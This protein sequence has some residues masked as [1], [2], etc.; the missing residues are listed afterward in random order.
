MA[1]KILLLSGNHICHNPR[2]VK[3]ADAISQLGNNV[4]VLGMSFLPHLVK[5]DLELVLSKRWKYTAVPG[6]L[7]RRVNVKD[8]WYRLI[9]WVA[10][11]VASKTGIQTYAQLGGWKKDLLKQARMRNVDLTI[12]HSPATLWVVRELMRIGRKVAV[13]FEDWFSREHV[14]G[15]WYPDKLIT[16]LERDVIGRAIHATCTSEAMAL[17]I[18]KAYGRKPIVIYNVFPLAE[19]P[20]PAADPGKDGPQVLWI[21]QALGPGRG[22]ELLAKALDLCE[23]KFRVTLVGNPQGNYRKNF[24]NLIPQAWK[25]RVCFQKQ[26]ND[27]QV[28]K[29]ISKYHIGLALEQDEPPNRD[30]TVTNKIL[31]YLLCGLAVAATDTAGQREISLKAKAAVRLCGTDDAKGLAQ[32]LNLLA[33]DADCLRKARWQARDVAQNLYCWEKEAIK[34]QNIF[35]A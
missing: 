10:N 9:R 12:A 28:L 2:V 22:L 20:E 4:E 8:F 24:A 27:K 23:P 7:E 18:A 35:S 16:N 15:S 13:D 32:N 3:E 11:L 14:K 6:P 1:K 25:E 21:S 5:E 17:A 26:I 30:L 19:A 34:I 29:L 33:G 31:Q